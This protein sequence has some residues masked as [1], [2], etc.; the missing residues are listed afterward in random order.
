MQTVKHAFLIEEA[1][2]PYI[3]NGDASGLEEEEIRDVDA[4]VESVLLEAHESD[5][6]IDF[7]HFAALGDEREVSECCI[8][9]KLTTNARTLVAVFAVI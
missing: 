2:L 3:I 7:M 4:F 6:P 9:R 1:Y 5:E 8:S